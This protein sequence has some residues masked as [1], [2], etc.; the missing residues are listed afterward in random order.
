MHASNVRTSSTP[1]TASSLRPRT[2]RLISGLD[3]GDE[4]TFDSAAAPLRRVASPLPSPFDSRSASPIPATRLSRP[5]SS[6]DPPSN[7]RFGSVGKSSM[8][9]QRKDGADSPTLSDLW[10]NSWTTL[11]GIA[12][13][14]LSGDPTVDAKRKSRR[15]KSSINYGSSR[16]ST[17]APPAKW[18]PNAPSSRPTMK[19]IGGGTKDEQLAAMRAQ[20]RKDM[21][22]RQET[23][24]AD[25]LGKFKRR[26]S[27]DRASMSAPPGENEDRDALIYVH[28]VKKDDTLAGITIKYNCSANVLRKANR[29]WPNDTIH[30]RETLILPV[31]ACGA[32]G[33][34]MPGPEALDLLSSD[35]DALS[36]GQAEEV[37]PP[38]AKATNGNIPSRDR[39][40]SES[41]SASRRASSSV[42]RSSV[43]DD[44][45]WLHDSWVLLPGATK[46]TEIA[47]LSRRALGYFPP[48][49]RKSN[50]F[51]EFDTPSTSLD[52]TRPA[53]NDLVPASPL[54]QTPAQ[55][56][57]RPRRS[58][59]ATNGYFPSYLSGPG[60][61]G[62]MNR[63]VRFP[64]PAQD[65]LNKMF[66]KHLPDVA[67]PRSQQ[68]LLTPE[69]PLYTDD[70]T[71]LASG[72]TTPNPSKNLNLENVGGAIESWMRKTASQ[73]QSAMHQPERQKAAR[74]SVGAP[75]RGVGGIGDL[76]EMTDEFEIGDD[77]DDEG[78]RGRQ[79]S[80]V[81][82]GQQSTATSYLDGAM[83]RERSNAGKNGKDD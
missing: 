50:C 11:Q 46:P 23:S 77:E 26:M 2:R 55:R 51:S 47:R 76:I 34:V 16:S 42:A 68:S 22:T 64:G 12:T 81:Y 75:G 79:G 17:S 63:N 5:S 7:S 6:H 73:V 61:V 60:G 13:D 83:P 31:D 33:R 20:K 43:G 44:P 25:T 49:R 36:A 3:E 74:A 19:D 40:N 37:N 10:G 71:P 32:K 65:G 69:F 28:R 18:G 56:P 48:A 82:L 14:L 70:A 8:S 38:E 66:A 62:T 80:A 27:D 59:S 57:V 72:A 4:T 58:S 29:M 41:T 67:P 24:Y 9:R 15:A 52:L 45:A 30:S 35:A 21:L 54:P 53:T 78:A 1:A 39:T